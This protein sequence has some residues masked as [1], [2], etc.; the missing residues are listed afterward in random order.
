[1]NV[2]RA[3]IVQ[4]GHLQQ[5]ISIAIFDK[6]MF[7]SMTFD[8]GKFFETD[9][10]TIFSS[11]WRQYERSYKVKKKRR[12]KEKNTKEIWNEQ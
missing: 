10:R 9:C 11:Q 3:S 4:V 8:L 7:D 2:L 1:M 12:G 5:I 6:L